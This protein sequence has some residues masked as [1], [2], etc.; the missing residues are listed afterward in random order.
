MTGY[1]LLARKG[2]KTDQRKFEHHW[3]T[4]LNE[5]IITIKTNIED[6]G[7]LCKPVCELIATCLI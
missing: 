1:I 7:V 2:P 3:N 4:V 5:Y 6:M